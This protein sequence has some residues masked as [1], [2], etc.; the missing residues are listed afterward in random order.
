MAPKG[1]GWCLCMNGKKRRTTG[2]L[3]SNGRIVVWLV[4]DTRFRQHAPKAK[5]RKPSAIT[6]AG[7]P[8]T[9]VRGRRSGDVPKT[10]NRKGAGVWAHQA[11]PAISALLVKRAPKNHL[12]MGA[13]LCCSPFGKVDD[14]NRSTKEKNRIKFRNK[15]P[16]LIQ[17]RNK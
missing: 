9:A 8:G 3:P 7:D 14:H 1:D 16:F 2:M 11:Q 12:G 17:K 6:T 13:Y 5:A 10:I 15:E 4:P